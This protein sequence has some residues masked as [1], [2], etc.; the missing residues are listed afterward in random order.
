MGKSS[1]GLFAARKLAKRR[2]VFRWS[3]PPYK[4]RLL[5]LDV[6]ADSL[7]GAPQG[8]GIV[9]EK[10]GIECRQHYCAA[11]K[12][13]RTLLIKNRTVVTAFLPADGALNYADD[14]VEVGFVGT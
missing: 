11:R 2:S 4:R 7:Q 1:T 12:R 6:K 13:V 9:L 3:Y 8:R 5:G 10:A 14:R